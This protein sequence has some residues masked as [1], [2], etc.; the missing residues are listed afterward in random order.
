M[1]QC[2]NNNMLWPFNT[3]FVKYISDYRIIVEMR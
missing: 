2:G 3:V 1:G